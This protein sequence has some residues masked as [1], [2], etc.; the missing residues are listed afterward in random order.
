MHLYIY[1]HIHNNL[2]ILVKKKNDLTTCLT[3]EIS[4]FLFICYNARIFVYLIV[5]KGY[6]AAK[7][8]RFVSDFYFVLVKEHK[9][10]EIRIWQQIGIVYMLYINTFTIKT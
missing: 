3:R 2:H 8:F 1:I 5:I 9:N 10:F 7:E 4:L 6:S